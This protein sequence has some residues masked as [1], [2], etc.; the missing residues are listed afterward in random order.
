MDDDPSLSVV[1]GPIP[2][3]CVPAGTSPWPF[4]KVRTGVAS[5]A[6]LD[7]A[8][9][10]VKVTIVSQARYGRLDKL[11]CNSNRH[12]TLEML[13]GSPLYSRKRWKESVGFWRDTLTI[14]LLA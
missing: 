13:S 10:L 5:V 4:G 2:H 6:E 11:V 7:S 14:I 1:L 8:T 3:V 9:I 12:D